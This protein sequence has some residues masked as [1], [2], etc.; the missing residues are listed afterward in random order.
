[1]RSPDFG[2]MLSPLPLQHRPFRVQHLQDQPHP[3][4]H[5]NLIQQ[6]HP[7]YFIVF[8]LQRHRLHFEVAKQPDQYANEFDLRKLTARAAA[9]AA[10]PADEGTVAIWRLLQVLLWM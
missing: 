2:R 8:S 6:S 7:C 4:V 3:R 1:M 9:C 10:R 5:P